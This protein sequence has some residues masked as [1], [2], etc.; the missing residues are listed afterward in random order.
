MNDLVNQLAQYT[1]V[2]P[3]V[4]LVWA[5]MTLALV[6]GSLLRAVWLLR[7][8]ASPQVRRDR[9]LSLGTWWVLFAL[10]VLVALLGKVGAVAVFAVVSLLGLR[11]FRVLAQDRIA[12]VHPWWRLAYLAVP[13][14]YA[15]IY[16]G[17]LGPF[18]TFIPVWVFVIL[19]GR[20]VLTGQTSGF[21]ETAGITFL[22]LMLIVFLFSHAVLL[23]SLPDR[24]NP[25]G[26]AFGLFLYLVVLT[27]GNDI[28]QAL[29]G[30][31]FGRHKI[32]PTVSPH[33][34]WEGFL[35]G[36]ATTV[37]LGTVLAVF[38][39]PFA[40]QPLRLGSMQW[41]VPYLPAAAASVLIAVGGFF[42]D[43]T[44]SAVKREVGV[45]DSGTLLPGQGGV[46]DRIDSLTFTGPLFFYYT[47]I[48]CCGGGEP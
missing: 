8:A 16:L 48:F 34:T 2:R 31:Q 33:K 21:L 29:W 27:E 1:S 26:G 24:V 22:G 5:I 20:L 7:P 28:A 30:R 37:A 19:V 45:K 41:S 11:E 12:H 44:M 10:L 14:H 9:L 47:Y 43:V 35:L 36:M 38:L 18:W 40:D 39:T 42:G 23:L 25:A 17:W 4:I 32:T 3:N 13:V 15:L 46:L 6:G